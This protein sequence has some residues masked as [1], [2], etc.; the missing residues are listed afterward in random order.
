[1]SIRE[2]AEISVKESPPAGYETVRCI[3]GADDYS[4]VIEKIPS[5]RLVKCNVCGMHY[6]NPRLLRLLVKDATGK[7]LNP[8]VDEDKVREPER[9]R[10]TFQFRI[11]K[12]NEHL[13]SRGRLLDVG[14]YAGFF[15][16]AANDDGWE[17][18]GVEPTVGGV[19][20]AREKLNLD[21]QVGTLEE[22]KY[23]SKRFNALTL[24]EV[25]EHVPDPNSV[26]SEANR[27]LKP[28]GILLI[29]TPTI[30]NWYYRLLKGKWRHFISGHFWF[31]SEEALSA[32]LET[33]GFE[34]LEVLCVGRY[35]SVRHIV[36]VLNQHFRLASVIAEFVFVKLLRLGGVTLYFNFG[37]NMLIVARKKS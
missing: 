32:L 3:C 21:V 35:T 4:I 30:K 25:I 10:K 24:L 5:G 28:N 7:D 14:C 6:A 20:Y 16:R 34:P 17:A 1:M 2:K 18:Y 15:L 29:E 31:F 26:L 19:L 36:G 37:D 23:E 8:E 27:V 13:P 33:H 9:W 12:L 11:R 22:A